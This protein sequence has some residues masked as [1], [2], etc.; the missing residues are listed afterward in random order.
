MTFVEHHDEVADKNPI[1][2]GFFAKSLYN[3]MERKK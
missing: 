3:S 1:E 2:D